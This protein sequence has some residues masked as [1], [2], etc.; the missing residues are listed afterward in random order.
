MLKGAYDR[1]KFEKLLN[2]IVEYE[3]LWMKDV[4]IRSLGV[5]WTWKYSLWRSAFSRHDKWRKGH[6]AMLLRK[7]YSEEISILQSLG[8]KYSYSLYNGR[9]QWL[10][11]SSWDCKE[12][13]WDCLNYG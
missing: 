8:W 12:N 6:C 5:K 3:T 7:G 10:K 11:K 13:N 1:V 2:V 9:K 4:E